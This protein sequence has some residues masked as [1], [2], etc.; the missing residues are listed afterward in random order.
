MFKKPVS[1]KTG[2]ATRGARLSPL[3]LAAN[4]RDRNV[5]HG[6]IGLGAVPMALASLDVRHVTDVDLPLLML[7]RHDAGARSHDQDLIAI[8]DMPSRVAAPTEVHHG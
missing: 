3:G 6:R 1:G 7:R 4:E 8:V 5:P 2:S